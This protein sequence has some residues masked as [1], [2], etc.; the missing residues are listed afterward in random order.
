MIG[1][2]KTVALSLATMVGASYVYDNYIRTRRKSWEIL[3]Q[4]WQ[5]ML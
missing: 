5:S 2:I 1:A 4:R 3:R